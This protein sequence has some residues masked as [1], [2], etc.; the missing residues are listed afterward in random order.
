MYDPFRER[1][2]I[3]FCVYV[4]MAPIEINTMLAVDIHFAL[5]N[6]AVWSHPE[7]HV[8]CVCIL[9]Q[10][11]MIPWSVSDIMYNFSSNAIYSNG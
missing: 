11:C 5:S 4:I 3:T 8:R 7:I 6:F 9:W 1:A 2:S 10:A